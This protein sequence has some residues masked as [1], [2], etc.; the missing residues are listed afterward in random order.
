M[1][2]V[3]PSGSSK[4]TGIEPLAGSP[5]AP[6]YMSPASE[7]PQKINDPNEPVC[8]EKTPWRV[9]GDPLET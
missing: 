7:R 4:P 9:A 1:F 8:P 5:P 6:A 2:I 3:L